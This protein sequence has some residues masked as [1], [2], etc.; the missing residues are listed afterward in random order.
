MSA[1]RPGIPAWVDL[2][3]PDPAASERFYTGLFGWEVQDLGGAAGGYR[4]F[5]RGGLT[6]AGLGPLPDGSQPASWSVYI[7]VEDADAT[8]R[9]AAGAGAQVALEPVDVLGAG[10][11]AVLLD[12]IGAAISLWQPAGHPGA[13]VMNEPG[14]VCW[15]E[16]ACRD[17]QRAKAFYTSVFG[18][19][20]T[21]R[22]YDGSTYTEWQLDGRS[23]AGMIEMGSTWPADVPAHW[24]VYFAVEGTDRVAARAS[25]LGGAV[26]V[27]PT[28][29]PPGRFAVLTDPHG[30]VFSVIRLAG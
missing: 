29:I 14:S 26:S 12:P 4:M 7:A 1:Y 20:A 16:L 17:V 21:T 9:T 22:P 30:A 23:I 24:M 10:R 6:V 28:D 2:G 8:V 18:W 15:T 27:P 3:S 13:Q 25:E 5:A 19:E 11:M